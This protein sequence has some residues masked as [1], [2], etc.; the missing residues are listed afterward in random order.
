MSAILRTTAPDEFA[1]H[2]T[3]TLARLAHRAEDTGDDVL[4]LQVMDEVERRCRRFPAMDVMGLFRTWYVE[5]HKPEH[6]GKS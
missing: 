6:R 5:L 4:L 3:K 2:T 1:A